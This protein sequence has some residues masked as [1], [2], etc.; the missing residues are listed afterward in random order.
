M[1][2]SMLGVAGSCH[3]LKFTWKKKCISVLPPSGSYGVQGL[4]ES[5]SEP[6]EYWVPRVGL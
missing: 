6:N 5:D 4:A 2:N 3:K 1:A